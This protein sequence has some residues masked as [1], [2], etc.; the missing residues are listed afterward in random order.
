MNCACH[1]QGLDLQTHLSHRFRGDENIMPSLCKPV[2]VFF[3]VLAKNPRGD[4]SC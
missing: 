2:L 4:L 1:A 3:Y